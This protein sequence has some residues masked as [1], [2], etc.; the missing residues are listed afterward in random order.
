MKNYKDLFE[1]IKQFKK[2]QDK[3]KQISLN[4]YNIL[5][6]VLLDIS[7]FDIDSYFNEKDKT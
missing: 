6:T 3:Q 7:N 5:T 1:Q 4:N 2:E